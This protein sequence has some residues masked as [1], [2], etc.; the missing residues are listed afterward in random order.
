M[1]EDNDEISARPMNLES[2]PIEAYETNLSMGISLVKNPS[3][4]Q[5][6][7]FDA[8]KVIEDI[9]PPANINQVLEHLFR[10]V[11]R[12]G[13]FIISQELW[14]RAKFQP[15]LRGLYFSEKFELQGDLIVFYP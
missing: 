9:E 3:F 8:V 5:T 2:L 11:K 14:E 15:S 4:R 7:V 6:F 13:K 12:G 10:M 1:K